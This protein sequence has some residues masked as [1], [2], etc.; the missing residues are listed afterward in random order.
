MIDQPNLAC[1][2]SNT[3]GTLC[4]WLC[5]VN[6]PVYYCKP[7][8]IFI[9]CKLEYMYQWTCTPSFVSLPLSTSPILY[10][11]SLPIFFISL[12]WP[13]SIKSIINFNYNKIQDF[14]RKAP[15]QVWTH[16]P[17]TGN[18]SG[19]FPHSWHI[20][21]IIQ[22]LFIN[23]VTVCYII[24]VWVLQWGNELLEVTWSSSVHV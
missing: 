5:I 19:L 8:L 4:C 11:I 23:E 22:D 10:Y 12:L 21:L 2:N 1:F 7:M 18:T 24:S 16:K 17:S 14:I 13:L 6:Y 9:L 15:E 20:P 3:T